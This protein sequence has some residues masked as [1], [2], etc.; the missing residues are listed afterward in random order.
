MWGEPERIRNVARLYIC[1]LVPMARSSSI[2]SNIEKLGVAWPVGTR[3]RTG[4]RKHTT[5]G[6]YCAE[7]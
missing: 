2:S 7:Y 3:M 6:R 5:C 1:S 4:A